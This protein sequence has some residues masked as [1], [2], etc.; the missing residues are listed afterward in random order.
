M[1]NRWEQLGKALLE[2]PLHLLPNGS[3]PEL[4]P[5]PAAIRR[6]L[7]VRPDERIGNLVLLT[8]LIDAVRREWP[9][10]RL[11]LVVGGAM[12]PLMRGDPRFGDIH[13]FDKRALVRN[14]L[15]LIPLA[16]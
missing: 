3:R 2:A 9:R 14:P 8:P 10:A 5:P 16:L 11:D 4:P 15:G 13:V 1:A 12:A 6:V 7:L